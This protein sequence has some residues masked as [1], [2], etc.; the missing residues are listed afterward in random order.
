[1]K[2]LKLFEDFNK[3][4]ILE[5]IETYENPENPGSYVGGKLHN[6]YPENP[7]KDV[8]DVGLFQKFKNFFRTRGF[9]DL[10]KK[11]FLY[12]RNYT[13]IDDRLAV[14]VKDFRDFYDRKYGILIQKLNDDEIAKFLTKHYL[15]DIYPNLTGL[16]KDK[17]LYHGSSN[18][19]TLDKLDWL[20]W[21]GNNTGNSGSFGRGFY[22]TSLPFVGRYY[23][24]GG[25]KFT[26][27]VVVDKVKNPFYFSYDKD[28]RKG[29]FPHM[30]NI[31]IIVQIDD[32]PKEKI[33]ELANDRGNWAD[34][35]VKDNFKKYDTGYRHPGA[36]VK[37]SFSYIPQVY[38]TQLGKRK[39]Q[40][41]ELLKNKVRD[42]LFKAYNLKKE[43]VEYLI[44]KAKFVEKESTQEADFKD[45]SSDRE[46]DMDIAYNLEGY[47][48]IVADVDTSLRSRKDLNTDIV[49]DA[50]V[51]V[52][53]SNQVSS[54]F[55][56][57]N[58]IMNSDDKKIKRNL[59]DDLIF[60]RQKFR[61]EN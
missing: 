10:E 54:I 20:K 25:L 15:Q 11:I 34:D 43:D 42:L 12:Q 39:E 53:N 27:P 7:L 9:N 50:E 33:K 32:L 38:R 46:S 14:L 61:F 23:S 21:L 4:Y 59:D 57:V 35:H 60:E 55:P 40:I 56:S 44:T 16:Y 29:R 48:L 1:M 36:E 45:Y 31:N 2:Y 28:K 52:R 5:E 6:P 13:K 22:L 51:V 18:I 3:N 17:I 49:T 58:L 47:D 8:G 41:Q 19:K 30:N 24:G 26:V 37:Y